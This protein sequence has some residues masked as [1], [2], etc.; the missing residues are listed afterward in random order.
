MAIFTACQPASTDPPEQFINPP[1][2]KLAIVTP[3]NTIKSFKPCI[4]PRSD[5]AIA[6]VSMVVAPIKPKFQPTPSKI[7]AA[8]KFIRST[9]AIATA[10][11]QAKITRPA[12]ITRSTP[13]RAIM[14]PVKNDGAYIARTWPIT[15][16]AASSFMYPQPTTASGDEVITKFIKA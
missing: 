4:R 12:A 11:A 8:K 13:K 14:W 2:E 10:P 7:S 16:F 9:P 5:G 1:D 15:T 3:P 6:P